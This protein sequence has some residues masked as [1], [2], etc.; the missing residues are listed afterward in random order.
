MAP[1]AVALVA[2]VGFAF[3][4]SRKLDK[5]ASQQSKDL[6]LDP[7]QKD[8]VLDPAP[9]PPIAMPAPVQHM[10]CDASYD[11]LPEPLR[12][13]VKK[14]IASPVATPQQLHAFADVLDATA[15]MYAAPI[16]PAAKVAAA[17][18]R[19]RAAQVQLA[20]MNA[21]ASPDAMGAGALG[22]GGFA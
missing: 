20:A 11:A 18:V 5:P 21:G 12:T 8:L 14:A 1:V 4:G 19:A 9:A 7:A 16:G 15:A 3:I 2:L 10:T 22:A 13:D 17:C 6:T